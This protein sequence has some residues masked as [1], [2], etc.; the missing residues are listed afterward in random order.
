[1]VALTYLQVSN[2]LYMDAGGVYLTALYP[3]LCVLGVIE[4]EYFMRITRSKIQS[5]RAVDL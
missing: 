4:I 5:N 2:G 3:I 1:M